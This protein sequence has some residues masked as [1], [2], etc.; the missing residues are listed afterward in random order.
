MKCPDDVKTYTA[1]TSTTLRFHETDTWGFCA[2]QSLVGSVAHQHTAF[3][4]DRRSFLRLAG[5]SRLPPGGPVGLRVWVEVRPHL[6]GTKTA[7]QQEP[8][9]IRIISLEI[10]SFQSEDQGFFD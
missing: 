6:S 4:A 1:C 5:A 7:Y 3:L 8:P 2:D 10:P 9:Q